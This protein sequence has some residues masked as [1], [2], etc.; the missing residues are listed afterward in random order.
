MRCALSP[1]PQHFRNPASASSR[2]REFRRSIPRVKN[3]S[4]LL[5]RYRADD[6]Q[7][8]HAAIRKDVKA[9][10]RH[11]T[12]GLNLFLKMMAHVGSQLGARDDLFPIRRTAGEVSGA[13][14]LH[15]ASL[16][17]KT[18]REIAFEVGRVHFHLAERP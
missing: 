14:W 16:Q 18:F 7:A 17:R 4:L 10:V 11:I 5:S 2:E 12:V 15:P 13:S 8:A 1:E 9:N 3:L 6:S